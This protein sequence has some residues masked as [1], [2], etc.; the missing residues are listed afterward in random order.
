MNKKV[1]NQER[2]T[3]DPQGTGPNTGEEQRDF[4]SD[5]EI[6]QRLTTHSRNQSGLEPKEGSGEVL[7]RKK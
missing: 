4:Q 7:H 3:C 6:F 1:A 5:S 2:G